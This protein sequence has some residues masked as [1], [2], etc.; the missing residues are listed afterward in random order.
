MNLPNTP[1]YRPPIRPPEIRRGPQPRNSITIRIR[2]I[3]HDI[4][5]IIRLN[6]RREVRMNLNMII[7]ILSLDRE[8]QA[9]E[10]LETPKVPADPEEVDLAQ[11]RLLLRVVHAVPD[12]LEDGGEGSDADA[13]T[14]EDG[15]LVFEN[16]FRGA[17]EGAVDVDAGEDTAE[18]GVDGGCVGAAFVDADDLRG[19]FLGSSWSVDF[20]SEGFADGFGEITDHADV[21]RY[22]VLLGRTCKGK[23]MI[24]PQAHLG[25]AEEDVLS[26]PGLRMLLLDLN[27]ADIARVLNNLGDVCLVSPADLA[28]NSLRK[29][30]I[31]SVHPVL[32]EDADGRGADG[33]AE[34]R[35]VGLDHTECAMDRPEEEED[36]E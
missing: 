15:R 6:L 5:G 2:I 36:D 28:S 7:H 24:L 23:R 3:D 10:P 13:G 26:C 19:V 16:V 9:A 20:A 35:K 32:P 31:S 17:A 12:A 25:A 8:E 11:P 14:D 34:W 4:R 29:V 18:G 30:D 1:K 21:Y 33:H 22:V 27:L